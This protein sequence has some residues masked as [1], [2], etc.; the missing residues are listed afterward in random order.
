MLSFSWVAA[1]LAASQEGLS[2]MSV[3]E[4]VKYPQ[5]C[6]IFAQYLWLN[7]RYLS[8]LVLLSIFETQRNPLHKWPVCS[9][10][11]RWDNYWVFGLCPSSGILETRKHNV[12]ETGS[13]S[14]LRREWKTPTQLGPVERANLSYY[15]G[16]PFHDYTDKPPLTFVTPPPRVIY[17]PN[18][19]KV[20]GTN[21]PEAPWAPQSTYL[22]HTQHLVWSRIQHPGCAPPRDHRFGWE[23]RYFRFETP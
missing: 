23:V 17:S 15:T 5:P 4:C 20:S 18:I 7:C 21:F 6:L 16:L 14:V 3:S 2:S 12:S 10:A 9:Q 11:V 13:V 22:D 19:L 1:Q 8:R